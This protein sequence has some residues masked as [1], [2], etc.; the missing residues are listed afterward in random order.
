[1][2]KATIFAILVATVLGLRAQD[3][4]DYRF[5][6]SNAVFHSIAA[7]GTRLEG[8]V[9][10]DTSQRVDLPFIFRFGSGEYTYLYVSSNAQIG[11]DTANPTGT[12]YY[13]PNIANMDIIVPLGHDQ[14]MNPTGSQG[15]GNAY[16]QVQG[17]SPNRRM[18]IE[19]RRLLPYTGYRQNR[20]TFQVHLLEN[21]D[22]WFLYDTIVAARS[23]KPYRRSL[24]RLGWAQFWVVMGNAVLGGIV[25]LVGTSMLM[26]DQT[27]SAQLLEVQGRT[28]LL[29]DWGQLGIVAHQ[30]QLAPL[31]TID[32]LYQ[33]V[34]Q[35]ARTEGAALVER[36]NH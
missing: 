3:V 15:G 24:T 27:I 18:V 10:D 35:I 36:R 7:T 12:G 23:Q 16:W 9:L 13:A 21:G 8:L 20:Y 11:L 19:Y 6:D 28:A 2:R 31:R 22:I 29:A 1:M 17:T 32:K 26:S 14:N 25:V 30:E 33:I 4:A 34:Q 5:V